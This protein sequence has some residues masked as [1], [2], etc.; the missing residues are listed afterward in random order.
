MPHPNDILE[1]LPPY[2]GKARLIK[3]RQ[4]TFDIERE[5]E[6]AHRAFKSYYDKMC[7]QHWHGNVPATVRG[8]YDF[9]YVSVPY[10]EE[11]TLEQTT[12]SPTAILTERHQYGADCKHMASYIVGTCEALARLGYPIRAFYR[13]AGYHP[14]KKEL[15]HVF[16]V[17]VHNGK[18]IW[19][20][21]VPGSGGYDSRSLIPTYKVDKLPPMST[22]SSI[23]QLYRVTGL[24]NLNTVT[25]LNNLNTVT[26]HWLDGGGVGRLT[27]DRNGHHNPQTTRHHFH[28][29]MPH[30]IPVHM[31]GAHWLDEMNGVGKHGHGKEKLK[32]LQHKAEDKLQ[33]TLKAGKRTALKYSLYTSRN[34]FLLLTKGNVFNLGVAMWKH[35]AKDQNSEGW[36]KLSRKWKDLGGNPKNLLQSIKN[37]VSTH[38]KLH[39][40]SQHVSGYYSYSG[41]E[42][43]YI[44]GFEDVISGIED[45]QYMHGMDYEE[46]ATMGAVAAAAIIAAAAPILTAL[47][48]IL[49][50]FHVDTSKVDQEANAA[51]DQVADEHNKDVAAGGDGK[52]K[53]E[54]DAQGNQSLKVDDK[55]V[56]G[57]SN[58]EG[59]TNTDVAPASSTDVDTGGAADKNAGTAMDK[60][61]E[62]FTKFT[63]FV[64]DHKYWFIGGAVAIAAFIF[65]PK[66]LHPKKGRR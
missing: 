2:Q 50:S 4:T 25:G 62:V 24:N 21:P 22:S 1:V 10:K 29:H 12:K 64:S 42:D 49:K 66:L 28:H 11:D 60:V 44:G 14:K 5:I 52:G 18:E 7:I 54:T 17:V 31:P 58:H 16:A 15:K 39:K 34:A 65:V 63:E 23:G 13:F 51:A 41:V 47:A 36:K 43:G 9:L 32:K 8:L 26:G 55:T 6:K 30:H 56:P 46:Y 38:N 59:A 45:I 40:Q 53:V 57:A 48:G 27:P 33:N 37:G 20:D 3:S 61:N 35:A 19:V